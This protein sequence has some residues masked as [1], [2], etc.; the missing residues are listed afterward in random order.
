MPGHAVSAT[1]CSR[2]VARRRRCTPRRSRRSSTR[3]SWLLPGSSTCLLYPPRCAGVWSL[4]AGDMLSMQIA[5]VVDSVVVAAP[6][7]LHAFVMPAAMCSRLVARCGRRGLCAGRQRGSVFLARLGLKA[8]ALARPKVALARPKVAL[9][10]LTDEPG[11]S[12]QGLAL[13]WPGP[14]A[15]LRAMVSGCPYPV[16]WDLR[17]AQEVSE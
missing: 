12:R 6:W 2:L 14:V 4:G 10:F 13:A 17:L 11:Q 15:T 16:L 3:S 8:V 5:Q 7:E 1:T 9:A